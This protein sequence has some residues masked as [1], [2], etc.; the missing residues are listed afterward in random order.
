VT[1]GGIADETLRA[2]RDT[3]ALHL[4]GGTHSV[5]VVRNPAILV[6]ME[7]EE[8]LGREKS[9]HQGFPLQMSG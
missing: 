3:V 2:L 8:V 1:Q 6:T 7:I 4:A 5:R 9:P